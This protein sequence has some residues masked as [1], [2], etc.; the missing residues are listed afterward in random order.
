MSVTPLSYEGPAPGPLFP[1]FDTRE[2]W[3]LLVRDDTSG[4]ILGEL[5]GFSEA[6]LIA[7]FDDVGSWE[8]KS[9]AAGTASELMRR[10]KTSFVAR[11]GGDTVMSGPVMRAARTWDESGE[12]A[13][14]NG[15]SDLVWAQLRSIRNW[16]IDFID[17]S[18]S[19]AYV[20][21]QLMFFGIADRPGPNIVYTPIPERGPTPYPCDVSVRWE[22]VLPAMQRA[23]QQSRPVYGFDVRD[24]RLETWLPSDPG[25]VFSAELGTMAGYELVV[26]RPDAN[27]VYVL[28]KRE[29][30]DRQWRQVQNDE[31]VDYWWV[32][33]QVRDRSDVG[34]DPETD[35]DGN[36]G[37]W[38]DN[39]EALLIAGTEALAELDK[40]VA[41]KVTPIDVPGQQFGLHYGLGDK[42][43]VVFPDGTV[44]SDTITEVTIQLAQDKPLLVQPTVGNPQMSLDT[45]RR[46][47][48]VERRLNLL[49]KR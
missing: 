4:N 19:F 5:E 29:G 33:E 27:R 28:G 37:P 16:G 35:E 43:T 1:H 38:P 10:G 21:H 18:G 12:Q 25:I 20:L 23:A 15:V 24:M 47:G 14:M 6:T 44:V 22:P 32:V 39:Q 49:E 30:P 41:V 45:F 34:D 3:R 8:V 48:I 17:I 46:L 13:V 31:S 2:T 11:V 26:E 9:R 42:A 40:P 36:E 7:R